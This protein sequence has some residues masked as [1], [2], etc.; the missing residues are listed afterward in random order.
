MKKKMITLNSKKYTDEEYESILS[1]AKNKAIENDKS[2]A[3]YLINLI[4]EDLEG[5]KNIENYSQKKETEPFTNEE[6][7]L[8]LNYLTA[9]THI[10]ALNTSTLRVNERITSND[11]FE[12]NY[13]KLDGVK[14]AES[15]SK[16]QTKREKEKMYQDK[17]KNRIGSFYEEPKKKKIIEEKYDYRTLLNVEE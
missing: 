5:K 7:I 2:F 16:E 15:F 11:I 6:I 13:N 3:N 17:E 14:L 4:Q 10:S 12:E 8:R 9:L 1:R